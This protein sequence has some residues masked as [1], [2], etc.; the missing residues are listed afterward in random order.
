MT[1]P[2]IGIT[3]DWQKDGS[4]SRHP[5]YALREHWFNAIYRAGGIPIAIPHITGAIDEYLE[6]IQGL[7][8]PGGEFAAPPEWYVASS[9][10][11]AYQ[12]SPRTQFDRVVLEKA[13]AKDMP[14]LGVCAGM[15]FLG[16][17]HGCK[18]TRNVQTYFNTTINHW[19][20]HPT[21]R[22]AH[23][24][25]ITPDTLLARI[26]KSPQYE[27]NTHHREG[28]VEFP[29][30]VI[31]NAVAPDGVIEGIELPAYRFALGVQWH[32]EYELTEEDKAI[33]AAFV[34][35]SSKAV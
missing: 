19:D 27:V 20:E 8:V 11:M 21:S 5:H 26:V 15:Q 30:N 9:E 16:C 24:V 13:L 35:A 17:V 32:P 12:P 3:L 14:V 31:V 2:V 18:M 23:G 33:I 7:L 10:P 25:N 28:L 22:L 6:R 29:D 1:K 34:T 4:F